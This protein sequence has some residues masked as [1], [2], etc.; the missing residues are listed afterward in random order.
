MDSEKQ[1]QERI[2][3]EQWLEDHWLIFL[4]A[5]LL[6]IAII[7]TGTVAFFYLQQQPSIF[8]VS[9][10]RGDWGVT[11]DFFGG[12]LNPVFAF[13]GLIMLLATLYQS[14][15]E[16]ALTREEL[17]SSRV[18]L[19][20]QALTQ[21]QQRFDNTFFALLEQHNDFLAIAN[22]INYQFDWGRVYSPEY[23]REKLWRDIDNN[24]PEIKT[25][26]RILY[27]IL[28]FIDKSYKESSEPNEEQG[29][30]KNFVK[31]ISDIEKTYSSLI[32]SFIGKEIGELIII[33]SLCFSEQSEHGFS[34][35]KELLEQYAFF[36]HIQIDL[37]SDEL[38]SA[39]NAISGKHN[40]SNQLPTSVRQITEE[41][42]KNERKNGQF[43]LNRFLFY[44]SIIY[45]NSFYET[46]AYGDCHYYNR[47]K[48]LSEEFKGE[49]NELG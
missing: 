30:R 43:K 34:R 48:W 11:G 22:K 3:F 31:S 49:L 2:A 17:A 33:N 13:L 36:E 45:D 41:R 25:Y 38:S 6:I 12:I 20:D 27:Q 32:R 9:N 14:Q 44:K 15:K 23:A 8:P 46:A 42:E 10:N 1:E 37:L 35:F 7:V 24:S 4:M 29:N 47:I 5:G 18:A 28:K 26:F 16:L 21:K 19:E 39:I 40:I